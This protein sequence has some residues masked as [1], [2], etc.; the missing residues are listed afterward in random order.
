MTDN[1]KKRLPMKA[2]EYDALTSWRRIYCYLSRSKV[3]K[4]IKN[5]YNRRMRKKLK[6]DIRDERDRY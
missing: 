4:K 3:A 1:S 6:E 2:D 5:G